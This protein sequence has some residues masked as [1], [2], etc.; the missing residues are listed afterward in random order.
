[1]L[2]CYPSGFDSETSDELPG[3]P[4]DFHLLSGWIQ[5]RI[6]AER[7]LIRQPF[8][9]PSDHGDCF[10]ENGCIVCDFEDSLL[11]FLLDFTPQI[12]PISII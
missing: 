8:P 12:R 6:W 1:M 11:D 2:Q 4:T 3:S 5:M 9:V 10:V 7:Q